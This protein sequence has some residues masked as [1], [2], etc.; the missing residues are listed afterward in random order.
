MKRL[1]ISV[2]VA[3]ILISSM[4][5]STF[6][7]ICPSC[8]NGENLSPACSGVQVG[9]PVGETCPLL[10]RTF[11]GVKHYGMCTLVKYYCRTDVY[12]S[13]CNVTSPGLEMHYCHFEHTDTSEPVTGSLCKWNLTMP[14][15]VYSPMSML[16]LSKTNRGEWVLLRLAGLI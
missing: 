1:V 7:L 13:R 11:N 9:P 3:I 16:E 6:A 8:G 10:N 2:V 5:V 12:C 14:T 15:G 4:T